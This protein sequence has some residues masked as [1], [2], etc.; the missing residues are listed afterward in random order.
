LQLQCSLN[1][2]ICFCGP[3]GVVPGRVFL[4]LVLIEFMRGSGRLMSIIYESKKE[5]IAKE[6]DGRYTV[7]RDEALAIRFYYHA[8]ILSKRYDVCLRSLT[9]EFYLSE[10]VIIQRLMTRQDFIKKLCDNK[11]TPKELKE[12]YPFYNWNTV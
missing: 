2:F 5:G 8:A 12:V 11:T 4:K 3:A 7:E 1:I 10:N 9:K 6:G